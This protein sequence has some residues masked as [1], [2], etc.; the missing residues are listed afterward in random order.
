MHQPGLVSGIKVIDLLNQIDLEN[1]SSVQ[2]YSSSLPTL[3]EWKNIKQLI[4]YILEHQLSD[5]VVCL[6]HELIEKSYLLSI[7]S[8]LTNW[9]KV[10]DRI[11]K[12]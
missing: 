12:E 4:E 1:K 8:N 5:I 9:K 3:E 10:I 7:E 11:S 6:K 2:S